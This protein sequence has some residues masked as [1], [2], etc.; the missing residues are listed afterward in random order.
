ND[1]SEVDPMPACVPWWAV[2]AC[3]V[4]KALYLQARD[5]ERS[6]H[7]YRGLGRRLCKATWSEGRAG[8]HPERDRNRGDPVSR[9]TGLA[10]HAALSRDPGL[11]TERRRGGLAG[12]RHPAGDSRTEARRPLAA[13]RSWVRA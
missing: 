10:K 2:L 7:G 5:D 12:T 9:A 3:T 11:P 13:R 8:D 4:V 6:G 1:V